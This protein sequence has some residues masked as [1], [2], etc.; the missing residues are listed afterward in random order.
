MSQ[1]GTISIIDNKIFD[2]SNFNYS[3]ID[4]FVLSYQNDNNEVKQLNFKLL[5]TKI[6]HNP[7]AS[8]INVSINE[9]Q[10]IDID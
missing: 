3:G 10:I 4:E 9:D 2:R 5:V 8:D 1:N 7:Q 6:N